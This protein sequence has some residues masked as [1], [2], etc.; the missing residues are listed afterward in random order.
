M[1]LLNFGVLYK[2]LHPQHSK[3]TAMW[4]FQLLNKHYNPC[5]FILVVEVDPS[6]TVL[7]SRSHL[8]SVRLFHSPHSPT[9][10][11]FAISNAFYYF[12][13]KVVVNSKPSLLSQPE[14]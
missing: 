5:A 2:I 8:L 12:E 13:C 4:I 7:D 11:F 9:L 6:R 14:T 1:T 3:D 10:C